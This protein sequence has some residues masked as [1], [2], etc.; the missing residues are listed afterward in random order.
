MVAGQ[1]LGHPVRPAAVAVRTPGVRVPDALGEG[2][3]YRHE[4]VPGM[5]KLNVVHRPILP[6][7][8][9][10]R[11]YGSVGEEIPA[12]GRAAAHPS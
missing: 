2:V 9:I 5:P 6:R 1:L 4:P 10:I 11:D 3:S 8:R 12:P 7:P